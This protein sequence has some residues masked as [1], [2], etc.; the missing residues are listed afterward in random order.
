M[1]EL[2]VIQR[3]LTTSGQWLHVVDARTHGSFSFNYEVAAELTYSFVAI[4]Q[5]G[6]QILRLQQR[7]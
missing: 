2:Y 6:N 3:V 7:L 5:V 4:E 1:G